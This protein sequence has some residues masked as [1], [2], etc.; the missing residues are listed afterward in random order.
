MKQCEDCRNRWYRGATRWEP[1]EEWCSKG[2]WEFDAT[3]EEV[4]A[5]LVAQFGDDAEDHDMCPYYGTP[6]W[7]DFDSIGEDIAWEKARGIEP[8]I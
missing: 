1:P 2:R 3:D 5:E 7:G 4:M 6:D 8:V